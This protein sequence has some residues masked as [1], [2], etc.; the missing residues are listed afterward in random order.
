M[1]DDR[2]IEAALALVRCR[3]HRCDTCGEYLTKVHYEA[4]GDGFV[5]VSAH[6]GHAG[7]NMYVFTVDI[8]IKAEWKRR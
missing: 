8:P 3:C 4:E 7:H 5:K 1:Y 2:I 6:C